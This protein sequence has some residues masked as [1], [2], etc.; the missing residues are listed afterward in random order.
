M[1][2][3]ST[4]KATNTAAAA[5]ATPTVVKLWE[6]T[7]NIN[8]RNPDS[9]HYYKVLAPGSVVPMPHLTAAELALLQAK[10]CIKPSE[11]TEANYIVIG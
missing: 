7:K 8:Y 4:D 9:E 1:A 6:V 5:A 10:R 2:D 11:A 3:K